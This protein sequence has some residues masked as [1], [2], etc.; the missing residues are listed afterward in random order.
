MNE[1]V[2]GFTTLLQQRSTVWA[3]NLHISRYDSIV[4]NPAFRNMMGRYLAEKFHDQYYPIGF[5]F[6]SG[7]LL[8]FERIGKESGA[9]FPHFREF[10]LNAINNKKTGMQ[11]RSLINTSAFID[12][13][14]RTNTVWNNPQKFHMAGAIYRKR[15]KTEITF[16]PA[17][18]FSALVFVR[19]TSAII[20]IDNYFSNTVR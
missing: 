8:A 11:W 4:N 6:G 16:V 20:Q 10:Q 18:L 15:E 7:R 17:A 13:S 3:H 9:T 1:N 5:L 2:A 14:G 19:Q 12:L